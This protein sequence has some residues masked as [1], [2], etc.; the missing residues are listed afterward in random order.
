MLCL[1]MFRG[2]GWT[3]DVIRCPA[4]TLE[5]RQTDSNAVEMSPLG[6]ILIVSNFF[7]TLVSST[8]NSMPAPRRMGGAPLPPRSASDIRTSLAYVYLYVQYQFYRDIR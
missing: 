8:R 1:T 2:D 3:V 7:L 5:H 6:G 4:V